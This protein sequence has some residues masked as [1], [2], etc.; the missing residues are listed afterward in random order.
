MKAAG[1]LT[2]VILTRDEE[3]NLPHA[4]SSIATLGARVFVVDSGSSDRTRE[5]AQAAGCVVVEHPF[6]NQ[7]DQVNWALDNLPFESEWI[8]RLDADERMTPEL[9]EELRVCLRGARPEVTGFEVKR[10]FYFWG[11]WIRHGGYYP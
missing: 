7:A 8:M 6:T 2:I 9:T 3:A 4:L 5:I 11:R 1:P 10:R